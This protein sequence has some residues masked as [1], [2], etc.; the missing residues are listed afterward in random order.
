MVFYKSTLAQSLLALPMGKVDMAIR[1]TDCVKE[2]PLYKDSFVNGGTELI[3]YYYLLSK[4]N[5]K[6]GRS[7]SALKL[8]EEARRVPVVCEAVKI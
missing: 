8:I 2:L 3:E 4:A 6:E 5:E 7:H 1:N